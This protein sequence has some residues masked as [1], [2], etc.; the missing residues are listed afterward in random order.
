M[1]SLALLVKATQELGIHTVVLLVLLAVG[2]TATTVLT[3]KLIEFLATIVEI[4]R[5][6]VEQVSESRTELKLSR[7]ELEDVTQELKGLRS[8]VRELFK[9]LNNLFGPM[10]YETYRDMIQRKAT[11]KREIDHGND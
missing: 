11:K 1:D 10:M 8:D 3:K 6:I 9:I 2:A 7:S 4:R 5:K